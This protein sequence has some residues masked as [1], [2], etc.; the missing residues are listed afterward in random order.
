MADLGI[1]ITRLS[2][3]PSVWIEGAQ[4]EVRGPPGVTKS[5]FSGRCFFVCFF[6]CFDR[7]VKTIH[8]THK[9]ITFLVSVCYAH[10]INMT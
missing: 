2:P 7:N 8:L 4:P 5:G 3:P 10:S 9:K 1:K 6:N